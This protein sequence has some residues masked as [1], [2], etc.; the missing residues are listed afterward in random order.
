MKRKKQRKRRRKRLGAEKEEHGEDG[1]G[2]RRKEKR[3]R[4]RLGIQNLNSVLLSII[5]PSRSFPNPCQGKG[6]RGGDDSG[7]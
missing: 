1:G 6:K 3:G 5:G 2:R 7:V 4:F